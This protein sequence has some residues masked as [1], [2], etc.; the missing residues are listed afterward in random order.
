M[1][2]LGYKFPDY[3]KATEQCTIHIFFSQ[4]VTP[5]PPQKKETPQKKSKTLTKAFLS[6]VRFPQL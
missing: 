2:S 4:K 1:Y 5:S 6:F 3:Y